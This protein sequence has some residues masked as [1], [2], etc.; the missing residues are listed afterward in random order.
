VSRIGAG[1][2]AGDP[3]DAPVRA[4]EPL[5]VLL[6]AFGDPGHAFPMLA[7]G[8]RLV[9]RGH[10]V[11][12]QTW[13]RWQGPVEAAGM[14]FLAAPE[15]QV[16]PTRDV[17]MTPYAAAV[18]AAGETVPAVDAFAPDVAVA[19]ILTAAPAL[20]AELCGVPVATVIPHVHPWPPP[21]AP[22]FSIGARRP[23]TRAG[24]LA[25]R[26]FDPPVA[27]GLALGRRQHN[28]ARARLGL[29]PLPHLHTGL[30]RSLTLVATLPHLEYPRRWPPWLRVVGPLLWEPPG[31]PAA[32]PPGDAPVVL[33]A[34]ST[35]Q[36]PEEA[37]LRAALA[38]LAGAP[39]RVVA[40]TNG[41]DPAALAIPGNAVAVPWLSYARTMPACDVVVCHGGHGTLARALCSG[42]AVVVCPAAGDMAESA[43]RVDWA[44][45]GVRLPRRFLGPRSVRLAVGRA[46]DDSRLRGRARA[47]ARWA[48]A[49]D[50]AGTAARE[51][52][53][54]AARAER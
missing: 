31:E 37:L 21:G 36:D 25:W 32:L 5:R 13:R 51:I 43:A 18:R 45:L 9:A 4:A 19:D 46:L 2:P 11:A 15:Y 54:W 53:G 6:G 3:L 17:P 23:R 28:E 35:S 52:E 48:A 30:S 40:S 33:L 34:P 41:R 49:H 47:V 39:V 10:T 29:D 44:G 27:R 20:A 14:T 1:A 26:A 22:P 42:C 8:E 12:L 16:F 24:A 50:G 7:L 38:G